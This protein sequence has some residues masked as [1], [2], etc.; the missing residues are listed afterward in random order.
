MRG[1]TLSLQ[2]LARLPF[3]SPPAVRM[4]WREGLH[5]QYGHC[6]GMAREWAYRGFMRERAAMIKW[7]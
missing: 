5:P 2:L 7:A 3:C 6:K 4:P 1:R